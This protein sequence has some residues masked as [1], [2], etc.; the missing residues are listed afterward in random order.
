MILDLFKGLRRTQIEKRSGVGRF[1]A[2][3]MSARQSFISGGQGVAE[4]TA[5]AQTCIG[6]W[7][8]SMALGS[9][10]GTDLLRPRELGMIGRALALRGEAVFL[11]SDRLI[12]ASDWE[13]STLDGKPRAYRL[14][15]PEVNGP[16]SIT[17]LAP[18]VLH[19]II[20]ADMGTPFA[21]SGPLRR[22]SL[23]SG[24]LYALER[25]LLEVYENGPLGSM[26][27]PFPENPD[28]SNDDLARGFRGRRGSVLLRES[29]AVTAAGGPAPQTDWSPNSITPDL[30]K[31]MTAEHLASARDSVAAAFGVLPALLSPNTTGP[32]VREAQRH[33][34]QY[35]LQ[36]IGEIIAQE[37][38]EKLAS[39]V[40][41][42][43]VSPLQAF[44]QG[45]RAR[46]FATM[47]EGL[48]NAKATG[49]PD[50]LVAAALKYIDEGQVKPKAE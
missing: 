43:L 49:L 13:L 40:E 25:S 23:T 29:V 7:E 35:M 21:G 1:T 41:I 34:V 15:I 31:A 37:A 46:A 26:I 36:P 32:L 24:M 17:A 42:D 2:D 30:S 12:P 45:G 38:A 18:E 22:A 11:I 8:S 47:I 19:F 39:P 10:E 6:L 33:L 9:V 3:L 27:V 20:G 14:S 16:K 48:A 50:E 44:D 4:L 28:I 5:T